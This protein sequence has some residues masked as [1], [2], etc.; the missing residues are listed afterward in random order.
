MKAPIWK[1]LKA[2]PLIV[3]RKARE[4]VWVDLENL[5]EPLLCRCYLCGRKEGKECYSIHHIP[6]IDGDA[7]LFEIASWFKTDK[8]IIEEDVVNDTFILP[9]VTKL[10]IELLPVTF[11]GNNK[12]VFPI[13][14]GCQALIRVPFIDEKDRIQMEKESN[15]DRAI[16]MLG[17]GVKKPEMDEEKCCYLCGRSEKSDSVCLEVESEENKALIDENNEVLL[18][19]IHLRVVSFIV[20][21]ELNLKYKFLVCPECEILLGLSPRTFF[22]HEK[23]ID[24]GSNFDFRDLHRCIDVISSGTGTPEEINSQLKKA[25]NYVKSVGS[26]F[27]LQELAHRASKGKK[28]E[29]DD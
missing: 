11:H 18:A 25:V 5:E 3:Y 15:M 17:K 23:K 22:T 29:L 12:A 9:H 2:T 16:I 1:E 14:E 24:D 27:F 6:G 21:K 19:S 26:E 20:S 28:E 7:D 4:A 13:C 8:E 10:K